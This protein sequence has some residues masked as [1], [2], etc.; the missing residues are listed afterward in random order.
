[1][2]A[3]CI[4]C[5]YDLQALDPAGKCPEC[6]TPIERSLHGDLLRHSDQ[7]WLRTV[8]RGLR[9][10]TWSVWALVL[11]CIALPVMLLLSMMAEG[12]PIVDF[13]REKLFIGLGMFAML[14]APIG[15]SVGVWFAT[16]TEPRE[17][18]K[19]ALRPMTLRATSIAVVPM[20]G[21]V[22]LTSARGAALPM[23]LHWSVVVVGFVT[24]VLHMTLF[25]DCLQAIESRCKPEDA[26]RRK[27]L[28]SYR[29]DGVGC[30][31]VLL[32]GVAAMVVTKA[33]P[34]GPQPGA[35]VSLILLLWIITLSFAQGTAKRVAMERAIAASAPAETPAAPTQA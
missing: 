2:F 31:V 3:R 30:A 15:I 26:K 24:I 20:I 32:L 16:A 28:K 1:M 13:L 27:L 17:L 7:A 29:R 9:I 4:I 35:G 33:M 6:G 25:N 34:A 5:D 14:V 8:H 23:W 11:A 12:V 22:M 10:T 19:G 18:Q 21:L